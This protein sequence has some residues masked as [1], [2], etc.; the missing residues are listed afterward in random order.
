MAFY[1]INLFLTSTF[2]K[3]LAII[4]KENYKKYQTFILPEGKRIGQ[5]TVSC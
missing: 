5:G 3:D 4:D 2:C 1:E